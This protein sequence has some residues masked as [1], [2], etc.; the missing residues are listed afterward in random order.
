MV[1]TAASTVAVRRLESETATAYASTCPS[2]SP[3]YPD[4]S[5]VAE[6]PTINSRSGI[7]PTAVGGRFGTTTR[8]LCCAFSPVGSVAIIVTS[9]MP[10]DTA[11]TVTVLPTATAVATAGSELATL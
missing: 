8:K 7:V 10:G 5:R 9:A 6:S 11:V 1:N 4:T 3:K 2:G